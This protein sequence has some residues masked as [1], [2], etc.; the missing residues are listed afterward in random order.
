MHEVNASIIEGSGVGPVLYVVNAADLHYVKLGNSLVKYADDTCLVIPLYSL[1]TPSASCVLTAWRR[2][3]CSRCSTRSSA[4]RQRIDAVLRRA[5]RT[6]P[7]PPTF[8]DL[9]SAADD[10]LLNKI[11]TNPNPILHTLLPP[12][13]TASQHNTLRRRTH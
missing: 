11:V 7:L 12:P 10:E 3:L 1:Q 6:D 13:S 5:V 8:G 4:D 2:L 9:C